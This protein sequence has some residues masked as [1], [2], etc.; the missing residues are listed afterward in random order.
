MLTNRGFDVTYSHIDTGTDF[1]DI[2]NLNEY[3]AVISNPPFSKR[4]EI[5][6]KLF[7]I[8][9]PFALI[10]NFNGLFDSK[11]RW[12]LFKNNEFELLIPKGRMHFYNEN[13]TGKSPEFQSIYVCH[14]ILE[15]QIEFA[16]MKKP[17]CQLTIFDFIENE[18]NKE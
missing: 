4:Q 13:C 3:D 2:K 11:K 15:K 14:R 18:V 8:D 6:E 17:N 5:L 12:E 1:F 16:E 10:L 7:E 9:I